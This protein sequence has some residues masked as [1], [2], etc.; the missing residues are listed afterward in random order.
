MTHGE[1]AGLA[2]E[3]VAEASTAARTDAASAEAGALLAKLAGLPGVSS[4]NPKPVKPATKPNHFGVSYLLRLPGSSKATSKRAAVTEPT[5][6]RPT[7]IAAV[8]SA[9]DSVTVA[10]KEHGI[11][12]VA[13]AR[14][15]P[16]LSK[17]ELDWLVQWID[18]QP[19]PE[20]VGIEQAEDAIRSRRATAA[21]VATA[22]LL[23]ERPRPQL[24]LAPQTPSADGVKC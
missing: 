8:Q 2:H 3:L 13:E 6:E 20:A 19:E 24:G 22:A 17:E 14:L 15:E 18:E 12:T 16:A 11:D 10:L 23:M 5:G 21:G 1:V 4:V 9:I 7:F